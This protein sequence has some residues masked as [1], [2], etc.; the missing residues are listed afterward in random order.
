MKNKEIF[1]NDDLE[2]SRTFTQAYRDFKDVSMRSLEA[3][4]GYF[5]SIC[6]SR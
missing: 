4:A 6:S 3:L 1:K 5:R 2:G